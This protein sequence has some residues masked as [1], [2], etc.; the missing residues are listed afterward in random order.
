MIINFALRFAA[1]ALLTTLILATVGVK[2]SASAADTAAAP[3]SVATS[4]AS[5]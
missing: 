5:R 2:S 3:A 1:L 4:T